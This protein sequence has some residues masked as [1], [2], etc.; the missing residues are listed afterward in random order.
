MD[1]VAAEV[2]FEVLYI[3]TET[4]TQGEGTIAADTQ[5]AH[6]ETKTASEE[7]DQVPRRIDPPKL[8]GQAPTAATVVTS[9][10]SPCNR[11]DALHLSIMV[12]PV[13]TVP[14]SC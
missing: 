10:E 1:A 8:S 12:L 5:Q 2:I 11:T 3:S 7:S 13:S 6:Q 4:D 14:R 9:L